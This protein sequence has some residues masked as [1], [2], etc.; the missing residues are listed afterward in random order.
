MPVVQLSSLQVSLGHLGTVCIGA[1]SIGKESSQ[2]ALFSSS[3][4]RLCVGR[5]SLGASRNLI[6]LTSCCLYRLGLGDD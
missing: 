4:R 3:E 1:P 2:A 6:G 5:P